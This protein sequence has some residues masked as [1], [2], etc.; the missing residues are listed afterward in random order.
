MTDTNDAIKVGDIYKLTLHSQ[1]AVVIPNN[2]FR[3]NVDM[4]DIEGEIVRCAVKKV[5]YPAPA[6]YTS[7][8]LFLADGNTFFN[9][10][11]GGQ[12]DYAD[13][14]AKYGQNNFMYM[15]YPSRN[16]YIRL[17]WNNITSAIVRQTIFSVSLDGVNWSA[18][19]NLS[20][21]GMVIGVDYSGSAN[22]PFNFFEIDV[23][24]LPVGTNLQNI[25]IPQLSFSQSYD[26]T[27][28]GYT[29]IIGNICRCDNFNP[30]VVN[31]YT[32]SVHDRDCNH[33]IS[34]TSLR[35]M[36]TLDVY[37][38]RVDSPTVKEQVVMPWYLEI[39]FYT[40]K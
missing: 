29:D 34:G 15:Y 20:N 23:A 30:Y 37:F 38:S 19:G 17:F 33:E 2:T 31:D 7:R 13:L 1:N 26:S 36:K 24:T 21:F 22:V 14:Y 39:V 27:S 32:Y 12:N 18:N 35:G 8:R 10:G 3:F 16:I 4:S 5:R 25:H 11:I 28:K 9:S 6:T 40:I